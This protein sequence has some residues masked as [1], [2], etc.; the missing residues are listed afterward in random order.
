M[1]D[2]SSEVLKCEMSSDGSGGPFGKQPYTLTPCL[3]S[4]L[5]KLRVSIHEVIGSMALARLFWTEGL[6]CVTV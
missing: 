4:R 5:V 2:I 3:K 1:T 6:Q